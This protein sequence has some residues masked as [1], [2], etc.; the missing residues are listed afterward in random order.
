MVPHVTKTGTRC[1]APDLVGKGRF[2]ENPCLEYRIADHQRYINAFLDAVLPEGDIVQVIN[3]WGEALGFDEAR[4]H[5]ERI[6]GLAFMEFV[7]P[8]QSWGLL[9]PSFNR[10]ANLK[11]VVGCRLTK[12]IR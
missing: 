11:Q 6:A 7:Q 1:I 10:F 2:G 5:E 3:D 12:C 9:P 4:R 8:T